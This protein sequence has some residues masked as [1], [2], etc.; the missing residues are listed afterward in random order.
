MCN[1]DN[2]DNWN[3]AWYEQL[4][5]QARYVI[6]NKY[7]KDVDADELV[8]VAWICCVRHLDKD[9]E[10]ILYT[11]R[12][13]CFM[14]DYLHTN[15][16]S[17]GYSLLENNN[18]IEYEHED[19]KCIEDTDFIDYCLLGL[20]NYER[21]LVKMRYIIGLDL[22]EIGVLLC[23]SKQTIHNRLRAAMKKLRRSLNAK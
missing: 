1:T 8:N 22:K 14:Y 12:I 21:K 18:P 13:R 6:R 2:K 7:V 16:K 3:D 17:F 11:R 23:E 4:R 20:D 19:F 9:I 10:T 5:K 15:Y